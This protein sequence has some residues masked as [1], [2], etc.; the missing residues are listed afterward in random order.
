VNNK[1]KCSTKTCIHPGRTEVFFHTVTMIKHLQDVH[2]SNINIIEKSFQN[3]SDLKD[4]KEKVE[5]KSFSSLT[6]SA[7]AKKV[8]EVKYSY[9]TCQF[10]ARKKIHHKKGEPYH[11]T[12]KKMEKGTNS[13]RNVLSGQIFSF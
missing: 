13:D 10:D 2:M 7:G 8:G 11:K 1:K 12:N 5:S 9:F 4:W 3:I 6:A